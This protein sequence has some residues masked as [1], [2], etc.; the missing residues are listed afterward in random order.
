MAEATEKSDIGLWGLAVMGQNFALNIASKGYSISVTNRSDPKVHAT[1]ERA[2]KEKLDNKLQGFTDKKAFID[3]LKKPRAVIIL[4]KAGKPVDA[5]IEQ[6]RKLMDDGDMIID[7][8]YKIY[9]YIYYIYG[10]LHS[11]YIETHFRQ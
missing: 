5:T 11:L 7:G 1:V 4:V 10:S 2:K 9:L 3:S 6:L 8:G